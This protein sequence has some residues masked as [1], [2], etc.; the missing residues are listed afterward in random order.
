MPT[1]LQLR[2]VLDYDIAARDLAAAGLIDRGEV[3]DAFSLKVPHAYP[4]FDLAYKANLAPVADFVNELTHIHTTGR[5]GQFGYSNMLQAIDMGRRVG[6]ELVVPGPGAEWR[7]VP[8]D[9][10][11]NARNHIVA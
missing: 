7:K 2:S 4:V 9:P 3:L 8:G 5:Q 10:P 1:W 6:R 11:R